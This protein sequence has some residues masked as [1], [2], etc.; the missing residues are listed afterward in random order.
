MNARQLE[1]FRT[2][3]RCGTL[4]SAARALNVAQPALSQIL[5]H[6]EDELGFKLFQRLKGRLVPTPEAEQLFPET[7]RLFRAFDNLRRFASDLKHGT[8]GLVR[9]AAS[10]PPS[11]SL[12]PGALKAFRAACPGV[13]LRSYVVPVATIVEMLAAGG[14]GLG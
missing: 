10:V 14:P 7:D 11:L 2:I 9:L 3:M 13:R 6:P 5:L 12:V 8:A 4:T 1:V